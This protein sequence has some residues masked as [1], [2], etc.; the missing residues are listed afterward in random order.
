[1][2]FTLLVMFL[3]LNVACFSQS[4]GTKVK[5]TGTDNKE[6]TGVITD[7][8]A[9]KYKVKYDGYDF[10]TWLT[11][12]QFTITSTASALTIPK[13]KVGDIVKVTDKVNNKLD[14]EI[15]EIEGNK[16]KIHYVG[17]T[18]SYYDE[19]ITEEKI[20]TPGKT[21][22]T[23]KTNTNTGNGNNT[24]T[25]TKPP[26]KGSIPDLKGTA[27]WVV[28]IYEKGSKP[29]NN[30]IHKPYLFCNS[31]RWEM[32]M[33]T[34]QM[35][36]Y[37]ISGNKLTQISDGADNLTETYTISWNDKAGYLELIG[38]KMV[39]RLQYNTKTTC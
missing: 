8:N 1:M 22:N 2:K 9:N 27:W 7:I 4:I 24:A 15:I 3:L 13:Y 39:I 28:S 10:E 32:Q 37:R 34:I 31:G 5:M 12:E 35:G 38:T 25:N 36:N 30:S 21:N 16:Y 33:S 17:Y 26:M 18:G 20:I 19:W 14:A 11:A 29:S 6:Y 23:N